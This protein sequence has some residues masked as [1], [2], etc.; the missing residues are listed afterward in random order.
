[1]DHSIIEL[2][3]Q[4]N[5]FKRGPGTWKFN[6]NLLRNKNYVELINK[7]IDETLIEYAEPIYKPENHM[8]L[9]ELKLTIDDAL[10]LDT[11]LIK[12][13]G[14]I[15]RFCG[16][17]KRKQNEKEQKLIKDIEKSDQTLCNLLTL[18]EDKLK[19]NSQISHTMDQQKW[20]T[21]KIFLCIREYFFLDKT[22]KKVLADKNEIITNQKEKLTSL[23]T[24][25][26][27]LFKKQVLSFNTHTLMSL[28]IRILKNS[29][30]IWKQVENANKHFNLIKNAYFGCATNLTE[31]NKSFPVCLVV[32]ITE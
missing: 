4:L 17:E 11:I 18:I 22:I 25:Y 31:N 14:K 15:I 20:A 29:R 19:G 12:I 16:K 24:Y 9:N 7:T 27:E 13:R 10:F 6:S 2:K 8:P 32:Y 23:Q 3:I 26:E 21:Y 5:T 28:K 1:M 30:K